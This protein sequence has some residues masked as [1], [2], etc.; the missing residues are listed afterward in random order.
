MGALTGKRILVIEDETMI[1]MLL[2][3]LLE[4]AGATVLGPATTLARALAMAGC[5]QIDAAI[6]DVNLGGEQ[7]WPVATLLAT[8]EVPF[9]FTTAYARHSDPALQRAPFLAKPYGV[10]DLLD[11]VEALVDAK[12]PAHFTDT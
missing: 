4:D 8:R 3:D 6:V 9:V 12:R 2:V 11:A 10:R 5:E 7:S 1:N